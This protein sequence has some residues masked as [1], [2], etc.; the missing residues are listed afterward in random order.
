MNSPACLQSLPLTQFFIGGRWV[1]PLS[2][3]Q[4]DVI[5]PNTEEVIAR[6]PDANE[7]DMERAVSAARQ[8]FDHGPWPRMTPT[9]RGE[10]LRRLAAELRTRAA[11]LAEVWTAEMGVLF[12]LA[13][14]GPEYA[15]KN[16]DFYAD[17]P[18]TF[19]FEQPR[20]PAF[21]GG[22]GYLIRE[23][24]GVVAAITPWN[25]PFA[26]MITKIAPAL[27]AGC[28]VI[29]KPAPETPLDAYIIALAAEAV[30]FPPGVINL[31][32]AGRETSDY[33]VHRPQLDKV[34]FTGS[35]AAG[36]RIASVCGARIGRVT[37]ELGGKSAAIVLDDYDLATAAKTLAAD[38]CMLNGQNCA[39]LTRIIINKSRHDGFVALIKQE[40]EAVRIGNS[41]DPQSQ[42]GPLAM[43][44]QLERVQSYI[45]EGQAEGAQLVTGG[46]RPASQKCG[47]F[48]EPTLFANVAS[49]MTIAQEEIFGPVLCVIPSASEE[50]AI[51][52]A[53]DSLFG[54][55]G[56]VFTN[57]RNKAFDFAK[58]VRTGTFA[59]N[60]S[61]ADFSIAFGGFKQSGLGREGG[62]E[63]L[64]PYLE[65]KTVLLAGA[66]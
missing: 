19:S 46:K 55:A 10:M 51:D 27:L 42:L 28:T 20:T 12:T 38:I 61:L 52:I 30:G 60:G 6:T 16:L 31:V 62:V 18:G 17:L 58:R 37:L 25:A 14:Y 11:D 34:S 2:N 3:R 29:M 26:T 23:P 47:Y 15:L 63:G 9:Q 1:K 22:A 45:A 57:D 48:I 65:T 59:Q 33:L 5:S 7:Q 50:N 44:R 32:T 49:S 66:P 39:A 24:V 56:A 64:M 4:I 43:K 36:K 8:A 21:G 13:Q 40:M 53:N 41:Y 35:L 54:L